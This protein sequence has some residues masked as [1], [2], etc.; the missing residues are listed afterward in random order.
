[1]LCDPSRGCRF[2]R[3]SVLATDNRQTTIDFI[4]GHP[5]FEASASH[6][7]SYKDYKD[8]R[9]VLRSYQWNRYVHAQLCGHAT[10]SCDIHWTEP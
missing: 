8:L 9:R 1:M 5:R 6:A 4:L 3:N 2:L 10:I 7:F